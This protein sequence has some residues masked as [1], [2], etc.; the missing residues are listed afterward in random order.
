MA[1]TYHH[2]PHFTSL[3]QL[4]MTMVQAQAGNRIP[5]GL[6]WQNDR[7]T[8]AKKMAFHLHTI[9]TLETGSILEI[10]GVKMPFIDHGSIKVLTRSVLEN[11]IVF[12]FIFGDAGFD[13]SRFRHMTWRLAGLM[14][15]QRRIPITSAN[16]QKLSEESVT[17]EALRCE[18]EAHPV[19]ASHTTKERKALT[20]GDW[21]AGKQWHELAVHAGLHQQ[22]FRNVYGYLCDYSHS[23]YAAALQVGQAESLED[24]RAITSGMFGMLNM[25]MAHFVVIYARLFESARL[26]LDR[27]PLKTTVELWCF[28]AADFD[29]TYG[30]AS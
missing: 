22:Y 3:L 16:R 11:F 4:L 29:A 10:D 20:K 2:E 12:A 30:A 14:D 18:I 5:T 25:V 1:K 26:M 13:V 28:T 27:S 7:Q 9:K 8:L 6:E 15:R 23:S 17:V 21:S 19:F 24:Q